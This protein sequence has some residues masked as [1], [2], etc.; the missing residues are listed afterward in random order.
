MHFNR[1]VRSM[2]P[3]PP[4]QGSLVA[5]AACALTL[6]LTAPA[7]TYAPAPNHRSTTLKVS[8]V[9]QAVSA[10]TYEGQGSQRSSFESL[11]YGAFVL[12]AGLKVLSAKNSR[13]SKT[14][15]RKAGRV[16]VKCS[17]AQASVLP[18]LTT[19]AIDLQ[20]TKSATAVATPSVTISNLQPVAD[21]TQQLVAGLTAVFSNTSDASYC[22]GLCAR[23]VGSSRRKAVRKTARQASAQAAASSSRRAVGA[24][25]LPEI[26]PCP[27]SPPSFDASRVR[28]KIQRG[29]RSRSFVR[30][31]SARESKVT[32][33]SAASA[34]LTYEVG[35]FASIND[36]KRRKLRHI[37]CTDL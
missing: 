13:A 23:R 19:A 15:A 32:S 36:Q 12:A 24:R 28:T 33:T 20:P 4:L 21:T 6:S 31:G 16:V 8:S 17:V 26:Q 34:A 11:G 3:T 14:S 10:Q 29:L 35:G 37:T 30:C 27:V 18:R 5:V 22:R 1:C 25:L 9:A 7:F 2:S